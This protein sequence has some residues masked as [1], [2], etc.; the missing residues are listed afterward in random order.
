MKVLRVFRS[1]DSGL[2]KLG[3]KKKSRSWSFKEIL[4]AERQRPGDKAADTS[5]M[6]TLSTTVHANCYES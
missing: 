1:K 6:K 2:E 3:N 4:P 5:T